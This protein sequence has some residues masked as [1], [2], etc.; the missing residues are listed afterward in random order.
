MTPENEKT[1]TD[2]LKK[3]APGNPLRTVINDVVRSN[4]GA[5]I[6]FDSPEL[7]E[8]NMFEGG[9]RINSRFTPQKLFELC[10][11]DGAI[12][13]SPDLKRILYANVLMNP[14]SSLTTHETGT[15]HKAGERT[16]KQANTFV[17]AVSERRKKTTLYLSGTRYYLKS[18]DELLRDIS[19]TLQVLEKQRELFDTLLNNLNVL[20]MS[21]MVSASDVCKVLQRAEIMLKISESMKRSFI[22]L[23][24]EGNIMSLRHRELIKGIERRESELLRDYSELALKRAKTLLDNI[25]FEGLLEIETISRLILEKTLDETVTPKGYRFLSN[26]HLTNKEISQIVKKFENLNQILDSEST[27]F[28]KILKSKSSNIAEEVNKLREQVIS[29]KVVC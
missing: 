3:V 9:F 10:K 4:L 21:N 27:E 25:S 1:F 20:E 6:V 22:E 24:K 23:G 13:V 8:K 19:S 26:I 18:S 11:M 29:G 14:D 15:R 28:E 2:Y 7:H 12:I 17:I 5:L 16:A